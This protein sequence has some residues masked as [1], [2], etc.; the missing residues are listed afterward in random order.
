MYSHLSNFPF[1]TYA[2]GIISKKSSK[3]SV[4]ELSFYVF[5][6]KSFIVLS[7]MLRSLVHFE[8]NFC[9]WRK[10][11]VQFHSLAC[12]YPVFPA[13]FV[14]KSVLP[15]LNG[16][17]TLVKNHLTLY[18]RVYFWALNSIPLVYMFVTLLWLL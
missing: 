18:V 13:S 7:H 8:L 15:P 4:I 2:F 17:G 9:I 3:S 16:L 6:S 5:L 11:R 12:G 14:R 10:V 1:A